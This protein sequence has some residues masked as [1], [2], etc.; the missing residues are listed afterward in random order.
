MVRSFMTMKESPWEL[1]FL[2]RNERVCVC[3]WYAGMLRLSLFRFVMRAWEHVMMRYTLESGL[4]A[5]DLF[6]FVTRDMSC[7][8]R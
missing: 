7:L 2:S 8:L 4:V 1:L 5:M 6:W 3:A